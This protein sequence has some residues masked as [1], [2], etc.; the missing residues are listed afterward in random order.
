MTFAFNKNNVYEISACFEEITVL[1][2]IKK[3]AQKV[4]LGAECNNAE[5]C[6]L[7]EEIE[8][9]VSEEQYCRV[10]KESTLPDLI[11]KRALGIL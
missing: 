9:C 10:I 3:H 5:K 11:K 7:F 6:S 8:Q 2:K 4:L 1:Q